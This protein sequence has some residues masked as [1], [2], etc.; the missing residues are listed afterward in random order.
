[1]RDRGAVLGERE[2]LR[3]GR[4]HVVGEHAARTEQPGAL[5]GRRVVAAE[6]LPDALDLLDVL[7][8][9]GGEP[10]VRPVGEQRAGRLHQRVGAGQ[11]EA[12]RDGVAGPALAVP[13]LGEL[14]P[15]VVGA[16][17][18]GEQ[19]LAQDPVGQHQPGGHPQPDPGR[20]R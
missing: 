18:R 2:Q 10:E 17:R 19:V 9:V 4:V 16:L 13:A 7:V 20:P 8:E 6:Q 3:Q 1:M 5:V 15:L 11:R 12:R 14:E